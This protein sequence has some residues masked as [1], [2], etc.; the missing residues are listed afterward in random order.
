[1][2]GTIVNTC[3]ILVGT[4]IGAAL[5][6][7]IPERYKNV[8]YD[9]LGVVSIAIGLNAA[10]SRFQQSVWPV[11]FVV[12]IS[13][14]GVVGVALDIEGRFRRMVARRGKGGNLANGLSTAILLYCIGPLSMLGPAVSAI[15]GDNSLL[16]TNATLDF[17]SSIVFA[18]TYGPWMALAAPVLFC[19]QGTFYL[20]AVLSSA[21]LSEALM[22]EL[23]IVGG[24]LITMSGLSLLRLKDCHTLNFLPALLV[25]PLWFLVVWLL[26]L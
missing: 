9:G 17:V 19:W 11:L 20:A 4:V 7:G 8:L 15:D 22:A 3:A 13:L 1:M 2:I 12:A 23:L 18:S 21:A 10:I 16:L 5:N 26:N 14:G 25:P 6:R 24:M